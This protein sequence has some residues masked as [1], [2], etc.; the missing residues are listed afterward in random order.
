MSDDEII[1][2]I[3]RALAEVYTP[4]GVAIWMTAP[5]KQWNGWTVSEMVNHGRGQDVLALVDQLAWGNFA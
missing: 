4:E 1:V 3:Q 5:H 2:Q